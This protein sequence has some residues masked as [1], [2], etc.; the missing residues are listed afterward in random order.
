MWCPSATAGGTSWTPWATST[1]HSGVRVHAQDYLGAGIFH[2][3]TEKKSW[4]V[5]LIPLLGAT[6][7]P[8]SQPASGA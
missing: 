4:R 5:M 6:G 2:A 8:D 7:A 3:A 1:T